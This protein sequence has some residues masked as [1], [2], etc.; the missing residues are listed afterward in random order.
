M[1]AVVKIKESVIK[2]FFNYL[3]HLKLADYTMD[4]SNMMAKIL[5]IESASKIDKFQY[6]YEKLI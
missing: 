1:D 6:I 3:E 4:T 2:D 5:F